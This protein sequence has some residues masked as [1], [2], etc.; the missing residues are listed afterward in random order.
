MKIWYEKRFVSEW[1]RFFTRTNQ[2]SAQMM[3]FKRERPCSV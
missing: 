3:K 2:E 1:Q